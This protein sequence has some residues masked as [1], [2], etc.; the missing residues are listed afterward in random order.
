[1]EIKTIFQT[2]RA[3]PDKLPRKKTMSNRSNRCSRGYREQKIY[4][5]FK[6]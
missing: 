3:N 2:M 4:F 1:M 5:S 6:K